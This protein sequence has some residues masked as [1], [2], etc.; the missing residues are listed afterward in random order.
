M[1]LSLVKSII[2]ELPNGKLWKMHLLCFAHTKRKGTTYN[3]RRIELSSADRMHKL[4][5]DIAVRYHIKII[6]ADVK[7][8][9]C[10]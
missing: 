8:G 5:Q 4:I 10:D 1:S 3:C 9:S 6:S 7:E 2:T